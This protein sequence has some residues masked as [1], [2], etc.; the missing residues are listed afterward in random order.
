MVKK[1]SLKV[2]NFGITYIKSFIRYV[3]VLFYT[4]NAETNRTIRFQ[5]KW[6]CLKPC[7]LNFIGAIIKS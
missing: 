2:S 1:P 4:V 7:I 3:P 6:K 5:Q